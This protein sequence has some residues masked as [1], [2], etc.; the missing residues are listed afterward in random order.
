MKRIPR[1]AGIALML[2]SGCSSM[3]DTEKGVL[4]GG[5]I[6][7]VCGTIIGAAFHRPGLGAAIG[8][9]GGAAIGGLAGH[10]SDVAKK[11]A[12]EAEAAAA[13]QNGPLG[14]TDIAHMALQHISDV[15]IIEQIR[16]TGSIYHLS[17]DDIAWLKQSGVSDGVILEMQSTANRYPRR[18]YSAVP[19]SQPVYVVEPAPPPPVV[20][21][22]IGYRGHW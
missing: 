14:L 2:L 19:V 16:S 18:V 10:D 20:G 8:A 1:F 4:G 3:S 21:I 13:V 7:A 9:G 17:P 15:V 5:A 12:A 22:G 11:K 6:G